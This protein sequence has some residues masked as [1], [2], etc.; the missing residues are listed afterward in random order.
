MSTPSAS[1]NRTSSAS[2]GVRPVAGSATPGALMPLRSPST[3]PCTTVVRISS[4]SLDITR[5]TMRPSSSS[6]SCPDRTA[7]ASG[8][9]DVDTRPG[10]PS[11]SPVAMRS[12]IA[13][14][15]RDRGA[16]GK[17]TR[18]DLRAAEV[19]QHG[20]GAAGPIGSR[21]QACIGG[22]VCLVRTVREIEP[23]H[24][25]AREH[26]L[27]EDVIA[28]AGRSEGG[29]DL[30]VAHR[31]SAYNRVRHGPNH[32]RAGGGV[33]R[34]AASAA[35][36]QCSRRSRPRAGRRTCLSCNRHRPACCG[37]S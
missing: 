15:Q 4:P 11:K 22:A 1:P 16:P 29:D 19:L 30:R 9:Y 2:F 31:P 33:S 5:R 32:P 24:I 12:F 13:A 20:N 35:P 6:R 18:P 26:Q 36:R 37:R 10:V 25:D 8:A 7:R 17:A 27:V 34:P 21:S 28:V 23:E 14:L 3:L